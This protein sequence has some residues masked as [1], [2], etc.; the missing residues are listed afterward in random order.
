MHTYINTYIHAYARA[1]AHT[2]THTHTH[3]RTHTHTHVYIYIYIYICTDD[4]DT[5]RKERPSTE[6]Y[7]NSNNGLLHTDKKKPCKM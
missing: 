1:R 2:H 4:S 6:P 3:T 5:L 7:K